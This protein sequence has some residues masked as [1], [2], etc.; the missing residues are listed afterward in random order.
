VPGSQLRVV[1]RG[2]TVLRSRAIVGDRDNKTPIFDDLIRYIEINPSWYVPTSIVP[3]LLEKE[4]RKPGYLAANGFEWRGGGSTLVQKPGPTNAL[5][6]IKFLFP[7][8]HSV[9]LHDTPQRSLFLRSQRGLSHGCV[10]VEKPDELALFLLGDQGWSLPRLLDAYTAPRTLRVEL[11]RPVPIFLDYR[12][13]FVDER[14]RLNLRPD[15]Y[16]YDRA[17]ITDF[18]GK[19][20]RPRPDLA[21]EAAL[22]PVALRTA[23][24]TPVL[25][26]AS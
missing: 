16:R 7:N 9:Y 3:E 20:P 15:L 8:H 6:R 10:R 18:V 19:A 22:P 17:G 24:P 1:D 4:A 12:T 14:G 11:T 2:R 13:A 21:A 23:V 25:R 26:P 5:G